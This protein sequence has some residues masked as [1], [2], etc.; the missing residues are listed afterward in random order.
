MGP[1][2]TTK[3]NYISQEKSNRYLYYINFNH[4]QSPQIDMHSINKIYLF[5]YRTNL[6][7]EIYII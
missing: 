7:T 2:F 5:L 6:S 3:P 4:T 1:V